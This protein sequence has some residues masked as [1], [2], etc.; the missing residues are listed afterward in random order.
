MTND[1]QRDATKMKGFNG[2]LKIHQIKAKISRCSL[3]LPQGAERL[4]VKSLSCSCEEECQHFNLEVMNYQV[5]KLHVEDVYTDSESE[6]ETRVAH[7]SPDSNI[8]TETEISRLCD[9]IN[10]DFE[11]TAGPSTIS[12][13]QYNSG[14]NSTGMPNLGGNEL[15]QDAE[16]T[17]KTFTPLIQYGCSS[18]LKLFLCSV[19]VPMCTEKVMNPIGPCRS[20]C[21]NVRSRCYPVLEGF[22]FPWP[23]TLNCSRF[24][25]ENN[26]EHMCMEG[27]TD[28]N[29]AITS[30]MLP[31]TLNF[32]CA[33]N[34][35]KSSTGTC[36]AQCE[37]DFLFDSSEKKLAEVWIIVWPI[38]CFVCSLGG[39]II[40]TI[41]GGKVRAKPLVFLALCYFFMSVGL[42]LR[43]ITG[44]VNT[45]C[46][47]ETDAGHEDGLGNPNCAFVFLFI[48]YFGMAAD[49]WW[50]CL[51]GW[52]VA[53]AGLLWPQE[54]LR[55]LRSFLHVTAWGLP[56]AQ[57]VAALVRRDVDA[58]ELTGTCYVGNKDS[59][60]LLALVLVPQA[61]YVSVGFILLVVG[62]ML[63]ICKTHTTSSGINSRNDSDLLGILCVLY[64]LPAACVFITICYEYS[65]RE[66]WLLHQDKP[67]L[68]VFLL[69]Y[70][71][72]LFPGISAI[73]WMWSIKS[74]T[75]WKNVFRRLGS[76]KHVP[77]KC[78]TLPV[79]RYG[80]NPSIHSSTSITALF[81]ILGLGILAVAGFWIKK[82]KAISRCRHRKRGLK[83]FNM[84][85]KINRHNEVKES[86]EQNVIG[87][88]RFCQA[89]PSRST[90]RRKRTPKRTQSVAEISSAGLTTASKRNAFK[91]RSYSSENKSS[92]EGSKTPPLP[93]SVFSNLRG[94]S[95]GRHEY[96]ALKRADSGSE[97]NY[98][99]TEMYDGAFIACRQFLSGSTRYE[100]K[101]QLERIGSRGN[102]HWFIVQ[103]VNLDA[104]R[105]L[106]FVNLTT[107]C[108]IRPSKVT[109]ETV[110]AL[111]RGLQHPY[112]YPVLDIQFLETQAALI[113]PLNHGGSLRDLIYSCPWHEDCDRK[114]LGKGEGLPLWQIQ[115]LGRQILEAM[116][117]LRDRSFPSVHHLHSGNVILQ[118][119]V[120]RLA[121]LENSLLGLTPR[122]PAAPDVLGFGHLL[123]EMTT[124]YE[125]STPPSPA[126]LELELERVPRV[127]DVLRFIFQNVKQVPSLE[128]LIC[129]DL[130]RGV[131]LREL[132]GMNVMQSRFT[133]EILEL[134]EVAKKSMLPIRRRHCL[135]YD[136]DEVR[137]DSVDKEFWFD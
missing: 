1:I 22:G 23:A 115:R 137:D 120:A 134:L 73:F 109:S 102:K 76:H 125:L 32:D 69:K 116:L 75:T 117:F 61:F 113:S 95:V 33:P 15:Q 70:I 7:N 99:D 48:Y 41:G 51:C 19:Y 119:G 123:F 114:Y 24:P 92:K 4:I 83:M 131:E 35:V 49:L 57:T 79:L 67:A 10:P 108:P 64:F 11:N 20:L 55:N 98:A 135:G 13:Q 54:K 71:M 34:L 101:T 94:S 103:D 17:L 27:P 121:G 91:N 133:P 136:D 84:Y 80:Q 77:V 100:L 90:K 124:G 39:V 5:M 29:V 107:S 14:Y 12:Q 42:I 47:T 112:I 58:D 56:A 21:E 60:T 16:Y 62:C 74:R 89:R 82:C 44:R 52:W 63:V 68:W 38:T 104:E 122:L 87:H 59:T 30:P 126:H 50:V 129:S 111:F 96:S 132:R 28:S 78:Q 31:V 110:L 6:D 72:K 36:V 97:G 93:K 18:Q 66:K 53:K 118:N 40:L 37:G 25:E 86:K 26:H 85:Q 81:M 9:N 3:G 130:F 88:D 105:L 45:T 2:T 8:I 65:N 127:A 46:K 43:I 128:E 106:C